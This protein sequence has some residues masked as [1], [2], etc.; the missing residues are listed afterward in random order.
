MAIS[1]NDSK[2]DIEKLIKDFFKSFNS[3]DSNRLRELF[4]PKATFAN[5]G[6]NNE[7]FLR[8]L[9][10]YLEST[11]EAIK[12]LNI[13]VKYE[14]E[15]IMHL[16]IIDNI[17]A[18]AEIKYIMIMPQSKGIHTG[19]LH[20]MNEKKNWLFLNWTDRGIEEKQKIIGNN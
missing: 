16:Q 7:L 9:E 8:S 14:L 19:L 6:N 4:H 20:L 11:V 18:S 12:K 17:I 1:T 3:K 10:D 13:K 15:E 5:I 2:I